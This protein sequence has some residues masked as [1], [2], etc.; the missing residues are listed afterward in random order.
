MIANNVLKKILLYDETIHA[1]HR[2][3]I[4]FTGIPIVG[5]RVRSRYILP[6][7]NS[8]KGQTILDAGSGRGFFSGALAF[9]DQENKITAIDVNSESVNKN[10]KIFTRLALSNVRFVCQDLLTM[11][12]TGNYDVVI[13]IHNLEHVEDDIK[14]LQILHQTLKQGGK[15]FIQVPSPQKKFFFNSAALK[16]FPGH[17]REGY[18]PYD[19]QKK[20][21]HVGFKIE[22]CHEIGNACEQFVCQ[23]GV[24]ISKGEEKNHLLYAIFCP[25]AIFATYI[26]FLIGKNNGGQT[27]LVCLA[28]KE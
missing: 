27:G 3:Y 8:I 4:F 19:L 18:T 16:N 2:F 1:L 13:S 15:L 26:A 23:L 12:A 22:Y 5:Y 10:K 17:F 14:L 28:I 11:T 21:K 6:F 25:I 7:L 9:G 20:L 24:L